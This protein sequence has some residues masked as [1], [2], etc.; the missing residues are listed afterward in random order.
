MELYTGA[1][2]YLTSTT[3]AGDGSYS[4]TGLADGNYKVRA[5]SVTI[6]DSNTP[7][8][9]SRLKPSKRLGFC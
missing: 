6:G 2:A 9:Q 7:K 3:T 1:D 4:F 8:K 5:R